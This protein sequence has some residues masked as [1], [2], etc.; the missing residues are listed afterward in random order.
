MLKTTLTAVALTL[1][2]P[3]A[4]VASSCVQENETIVPVEFAPG[5]STWHHHG[6]GTRFIGHFSEG[7]K[8]LITA[9][10]GTPVEPWQLSI[11][12]IAT[13]GAADWTTK[14]TPGP[15]NTFM[16]ATELDRDGILNVTIPKTGNYAISHGPCSSWGTLGDVE[17]TDVTRTGL[18]DVTLGMTIAEVTEG[19][20]WGHPERINRT[21]T[22]AGDDE[23]W[24]YSGGRYLYFHNGE[25]RAIQDKPTTARPPGGYPSPGYP[26]PDLE[27]Q[28]GKALGTGPDRTGLLE[29]RR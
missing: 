19:T 6:V 4:A 7:Q 12:N 9:A 20:W 22:A 8:L 25:L 28:H 13:S 18:P 23:Q 21:R 14:Y 15:D 16:K 5:H 11:D 10:G 24:V 26:S 1:A 27:G 3:A 2:I 17:I 29:L